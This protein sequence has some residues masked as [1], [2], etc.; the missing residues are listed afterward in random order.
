MRNNREEEG[1]KVRIS[2]PPS[3]SLQFSIETIMDS[4]LKFDAVI[5]KEVT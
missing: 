4:L 2:S 3:S 1:G 5:D